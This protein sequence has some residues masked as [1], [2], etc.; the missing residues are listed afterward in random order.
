V[1]KTAKG[2][3]AQAP[4]QGAGEGPLVIGHASDPTSL[5]GTAFVVGGG[6]GPRD[7][8]LSEPPTGGAKRTEKGQRSASCSLEIGL[9]PDSP[10]PPKS[11]TSSPTIGQ[12]RHGVTRAQRRVA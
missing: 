1:A 10:S 2:R 7:Q 12:K 8:K 4:W 11:A 5:G 6:Q 9:V 3:K